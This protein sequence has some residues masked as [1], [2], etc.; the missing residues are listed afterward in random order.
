MPVISVKMLKGRSVAQKEALIRELAQG[1]MRALN[2]PEASVRI[3]LTE[4]D[5]EHWGVGARTKAYM[6]KDK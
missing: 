4:I 6:D 5:A 3:I 1:A 2:V